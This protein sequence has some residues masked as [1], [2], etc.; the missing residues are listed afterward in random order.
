MDRTGTKV[1]I[2]AG[3]VAFIAVVGFIDSRFP[4]LTFALFYLIPVFLTSWYIGR[5]VGAG[6]A[7]GSAVFGLVAD[8]VSDNA[9]IGY[10]YANGAFRLVLLLM[11][12]SIVGRLHVAIA[13]ERLTATTRGELMRRVA[14]GAQ[15]PLGDINARVVDLGFEL[16]ASA[17]D[18]RQLIGEIVQASGRLARLVEKLEEEEPVRRVGNDS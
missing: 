6:I 11:V 13:R 15:E 1:G 16:S 2:I 3:A 10:A 18:R 4:D 17:P 8:I 12:G 14:A 5:A 9:S 7:T